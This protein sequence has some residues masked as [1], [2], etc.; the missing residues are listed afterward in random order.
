M[1]YRCLEESER[2]D[3]RLLTPVP[4]RRQ[5]LQG[6]FEE[7]EEERIRIIIRRRRRIKRRRPNPL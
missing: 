1:S 5:I 6:N 7:A 3:H 4:C 2:D